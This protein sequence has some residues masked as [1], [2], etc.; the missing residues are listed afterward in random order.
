MLWF[1]SEEVPVLM[2]RN[3]IQQV[4]AFYPE[5]LR[6]QIEME[7]PGLALQASQLGLE[8]MLAERQGLRYAEAVVRPDFPKM[9]RVCWGATNLLQ[10]RVPPNIVLALKDL[11]E[12]AA[13]GGLDPAR[14]LLFE[15]ATRRDDPEAALCRFL[16][17]VAVR[18][19]LVIA[20]WDIPEVEACGALADVENAA[21]DILREVLGTGAFSDPD[22]RPLHLLI[23]E[24]MLRLRADVRARFGHAMTELST[25]WSEM[26]RSAEAI[27]RV[28][29]LDARDAAMFQPG[30][31]SGPLGSQQIADRFPHHFP[32]ANAME[33]RRSRRARRTEAAN[34]A[35]DRF[36]DLIREIDGDL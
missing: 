12:F 13:L 9:G 26:F 22:L 15:L 24:M 10:W 11:L 16:L 14:R 35:E 2:V 33:Q 1:I 32:S 6:E 29:E 5:A 8:I 25:A 28:R 36:I 7:L 27:G 18:L 31:S 20:T 23:S 21:E 19:N 30:R 4:I 3:M 34:L 17:W